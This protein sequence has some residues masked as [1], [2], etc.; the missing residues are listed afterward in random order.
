MAAPLV[1]KAGTVALSSVVEGL[2]V[3]EPE[4]GEWCGLDLMSPFPDGGVVDPVSRL[5]PKRVGVLP[6]ED[7]VSVTVMGSGG[8]CGEDDWLCEC[9]LK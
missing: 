2:R 6:L 4:T 1:G 7:P 8:L 3:A 5:I 9:S